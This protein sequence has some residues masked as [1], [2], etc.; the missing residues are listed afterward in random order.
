MREFFGGLKEK[1]DY[2]RFYCYLLVILCK[3]DV[4][5]AAKLFLGDGESFEFR[6]NYKKNDYSYQGVFK[7][8]SKTDLVWKV[9]VIFLSLTRI[10]LQVMDGVHRIISY[11]LTGLGLQP[12]KGSARCFLTETKEVL[13][14]R[15]ID[16]T[17]IYHHMISLHL[18]ALSDETLDYKY[19]LQT[20][21]RDMTADNSVLL[22]NTVKLHD[23]ISQF[24]YKEGEQDVAFV[25]TSFDDLKII[26]KYCQM[27]SRDPSRRY[28]Y[29]INSNTGRLDLYND[30][31]KTTD[32]KEAERNK[33]LMKRIKEFY[34][35]PKRR[36]EPF[37]CQ[38]MTY[39]WFIWRM[40]YLLGQFLKL[41]LTEKNYLVLNHSIF[42]TP[43]HITKG[44]PTVKAV[45]HQVMKQFTGKDENAK[46]WV[47][48][49]IS[50]GFEHDDIP[51]LLFVIF[52]L[53]IMLSCVH[54]SPGSI[55]HHYLKTSKIYDTFLSLNPPRRSINETVHKG[56]LVSG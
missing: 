11:R 43:R 41:V 45:V 35:L 22:I 31:G 37:T 12:A 7:L 33:K 30:D 15:F 29:I 13:D 47:K 16:D 39:M 55:L 49:R 4:D 54:G 5:V 25:E 10:R 36:Y 20:I 42:K 19:A 40:E 34:T 17:E 46:S 2:V 53:M 23:M 48:Y 51:K 1:E 6:P 28:R 26:L 56:I 8:Y 24:I 38:E 21:N 44:L 52:R 9:S 27:V 18:H 32:P 3:G 50:S 14:T